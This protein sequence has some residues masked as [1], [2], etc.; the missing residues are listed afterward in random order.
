MKHKAVIHAR[1]ALHKRKQH[2]TKYY[3]F[4]GG[5]LWQQ[6]NL[7]KQFWHSDEI[8]WKMIHV[9]SS[10]KLEFMIQ[11]MIS[12]QPASSVFNRYFLSYEKW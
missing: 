11:E 12:Q 10:I 7:H 2:K 1:A 3:F 9:S 5:K 6:N 8:F 4:Y